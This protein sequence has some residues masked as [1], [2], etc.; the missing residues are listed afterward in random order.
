MEENEN[1]SVDSAKVNGDKTVWTTAKYEIDNNTGELKTRRIKLGQNTAQGLAISD[2]S[3]G[4]AVSDLVWKPGKI[5]DYMVDNTPAEFR[6]LQ[7]RLDEYARLSTNL[8]F[9]NAHSW[10]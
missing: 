6:V 9:R 3:S 7:N 5:G 4:L 2:P 10:G 1:I 8:I